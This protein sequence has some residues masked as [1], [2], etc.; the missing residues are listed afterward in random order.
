MKAPHEEHLEQG[1]L[2]SRGEQDA[3]AEQAVGEIA[4]T[5]ERTR[6]AQLALLDGAGR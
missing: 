3:G 4:A 5:T 1:I 2:V 6:T